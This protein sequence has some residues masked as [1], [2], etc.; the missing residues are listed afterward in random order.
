[1]RELYHGLFSIFVAQMSRKLLFIVNPNAGKKMSGTIMKTINKEF[2]ASIQYE[3]VVWKD[4]AHFEEI[5][6]MLR[7]GNYTDAVAVGGD[8]TV[9]R[10][11]AALLNTG[12]ALGILPA[13]SGNGM[14]RSL[15]LSMR[16]EEAIRQI[17]AGRTEMIDS[18]SVN[19]LPFFCTSGLGFDAHI[20][21]LFATSVKRGLQSYI[22]ITTRELFRY[23]AKEYTVTLDDHTFIKKAFL[24]TI[25]N[26]GQYGN[27]FYIAPQA[28]MKDGLFHVVVLKPFNVLKLPGLMRRILTRKAFLAASIETYTTKRVV[29]KRGEPDSIH[30]D[31]EPSGQGKEIVFEMNPLSLKVIVGDKFKAA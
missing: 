5:I 22:K 11:A 3:I 27:D 12:I 24:I 2:P 1:M 13:G 31:G 9:N 8:G 30:Y 17:A 6:T 15:G 16:R 4:P 29:V 26:A 19:G 25:A 18:G 10:V 14:A 7:T 28:S 23:R 20:G 21:K